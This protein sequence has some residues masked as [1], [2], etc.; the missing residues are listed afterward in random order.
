MLWGLN[1]ARL[2]RAATL[3]SSAPSPAASSGS[4]PPSSGRTARPNKLGVAVAGRHFDLFGHVLLDFLRCDTYRPGRTKR[5]QAFK[6]PSGEAPG[7]MGILNKPRVFGIVVRLVRPD[8]F[9]RFRI[10]EEGLG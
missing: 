1:T 8:P 6:M 5:A 2:F 3:T 4:A 9:A 10:S 7:G